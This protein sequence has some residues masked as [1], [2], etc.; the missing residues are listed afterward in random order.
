MVTAPEFSHCMAVNLPNT[1]LWSF[2]ALRL[3]S[4]SLLENPQIFYNCLELFSI[5]CSMPFRLFSSMAFRICPRITRELLPLASINQCSKPQFWGSDTTILPHLATLHTELI[6]EL[7]NI[8]L[9]KVKYSLCVI[10]FKNLLNRSSL[11]R[12]RSNIYQ[13]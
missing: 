3:P 4:R 9:T 11:I 13:F 10:V 5:A 7:N 8:L 1:N 12:K 6:T 2:S